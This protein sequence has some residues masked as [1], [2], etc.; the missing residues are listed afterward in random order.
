MHDEN[1]SQE[2][3]G[4]EVRRRTLGGTMLWDIYFYVALKWGRSKQL[5]VWFHCYRVCAF[6]YDKHK[7][8]K[9][10]LCHV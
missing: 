6:V 9:R 10:R 7:H 1:P 5:G 4:Q 2:R 8:L 3:E